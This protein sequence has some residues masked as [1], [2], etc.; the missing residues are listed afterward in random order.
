MFAR[1]RQFV[2]SLADRKAMKNAPASYETK[3]AR[4]KRLQLPHPG[5]PARL[6]GLRKLRRH[7]PAKEK[8]LIVKPF[9]EM[10]KSQAANWEFA[11]SLPEPKIEIKRNSFRKPY[12]KPLFEFSGACAGCGDALREAHDTAVWR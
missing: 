12:L 1:T 9:A 10:E 11:A 3:P 7:C 8:A 4:G 6:H 5:F 2:R